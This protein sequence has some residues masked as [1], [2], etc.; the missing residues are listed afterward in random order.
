MYENIT[1]DV[2][3]IITMEG[4]T[5]S[6]FWFFLNP[7]CRASFC[8]HP[9][10]MESSDARGAVW[11]SSILCLKLAIGCR[12][13]E[14]E[15]QQVQLCGHKIQPFFITT[16]SAS[17]TKTSWLLTMR[18]LHLIRPVMAVLPEVEAPDRKVR[19]WWELASLGDENFG[20]SDR[21]WQWE[22]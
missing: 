22:S 21:P 5:G 2:I 8:A 20:I 12:F 10:P 16:L 11:L 18:F 3:N 13:C 19:F 7:K 9:K 6:I 4:Q 17:T 14:W 15:K 1:E